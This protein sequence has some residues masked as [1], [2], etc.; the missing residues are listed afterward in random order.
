MT[1]FFI[2]GFHPALSLAEIY[3]WLGSRAE[4]KMAAKDCLVVETANFEAAAAIKRLGGTVK[5]GMITA[6]VSLTGLPE[7]VATHCRPKADHKFFFG[8]SGYG[9]VGSLKN[10]AMKV[11]AALTAKGV[12][13]RW[14]TSR[15]RNLSSAAVEQ[16]GLL[17]R[18]QDFVLIKQG[19]RILLGETLVVQPFKEWSW[20]DY[21]R[22]D[23]DDYAGMLPPKLAL[24][25]INLSKPHS[26]NVILDPFCGSGTVLSEAALWGGQRLIGGDI[27][28]AALDQTKHN[29]AWLKSKYQNLDFRC[30]LVQC[31][32]RKLFEVL[33][34]SSVDRLVT[35]PYLGPAR[36]PRLLAKINRDLGVLYGYFLAAAA[37]VMKADGRLVMV[38]PILLNGAKKIW[39]K[40]NHPDWVMANPLPT[41]WQEIKPQLSPRQTLVYGRAGQKVWREIVI[42]IKK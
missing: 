14:V 23:R 20:R 29:L 13:S 33:E 16:S 22:P 42:L 30:R 26:D 21:G 11:K 41:T 4:Y 36:G 27:S 28:L 34:P 8:F 39:L 9:A 5:I 35:E 17:N 37:R 12:S 2:L 18:G 6:T 3:S 19:G 40:P 24:M 31:D 32:A 25:M 38:W 10:L 15:E 7:A 1:Y